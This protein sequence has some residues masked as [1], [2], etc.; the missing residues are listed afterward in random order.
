MWSIRADAEPYLNQLVKVLKD[1]PA[2]TVQ[3]QSHCDCRGSNGFNDALSQKRADAVVEYLISKG[4]PRAKL[5]SRG[6]GKRKLLNDCNCR[7]TECSDAKHA[8]NRRT[9]FIVVAK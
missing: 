8:E 6:L 5:Q 9:E 7:R 3:I 4:I 2:L 1:N